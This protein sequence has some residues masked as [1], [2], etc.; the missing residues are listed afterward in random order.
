MIYHNLLDSDLA[1]LKAS[2]ETAVQIVSA[3]IALSRD[4][5]VDTSLIEVKSILLAP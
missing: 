4:L 2:G 3:K 5:F 1:L